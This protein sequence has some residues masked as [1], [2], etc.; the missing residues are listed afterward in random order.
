MK[1][2]KF[3]PL[4]LAFLPIG[5]FDL[6]LD[7]SDLKF[8]VSLHPLYTDKDL[9]FDEKLLGTWS[10][11]D[12]TL[13]FQK[14]KDANSYNL[15]FFNPGEENAQF[16]AHL[17]RFDDMLFLDLSSGISYKDCNDFSAI[18]LVSGH[19]FIKIKA[20]ESKLQMQFAD[21]SEID[22]DL[23]KQEIVDDRIIFT[24]S[25]KELQKF[26][27]DNINDEA[28]FDKPSIFK[29]ILPKES[30]NYNNIEPNTNEPSKS[31]GK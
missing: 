1:F 22:S 24:A 14:S 7:L 2:K 16:I 6:D 18:L 3:I 28:L 31:K 26:F 13:V 29:R 5:C 20:V 19:M 21:I 11:G 25:P 17:V 12:T 15:I 4:L 8:P 23:L 27:K 10:D 30:N 9:T